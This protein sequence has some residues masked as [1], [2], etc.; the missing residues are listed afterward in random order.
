MPTLAELKERYRQSVLRPSQPQSVSTCAPDEIA[1]LRE[2]QDCLNARLDKGIRFLNDLAQRVGQDSSE[3]D[4]Y[5]AEWLRLK[6]EYEAVCDEMIVLE[7]RKELTEWLKT[8]PP[9]RGRRASDE[10]EDGAQ[11]NAPANPSVRA[12]KNAR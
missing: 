9:P 2:K 1:V 10:K 5:F 12:C 7:A 8:L 4:H 6:D 11:P 3:F